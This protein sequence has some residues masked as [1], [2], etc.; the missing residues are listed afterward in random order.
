MEARLEIRCYGSQKRL[1]ERAAE[2]SVHPDLSSWMR[3]ILTHEANL[4]LLGEP[5][6]AVHSGNERSPD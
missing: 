4:Q 6:P 3:Y 1:W 5:V 2:A